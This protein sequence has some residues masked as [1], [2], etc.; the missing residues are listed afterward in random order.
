M[1][2][3][4]CSPLTRLPVC[5]YVQLQP[6]SDK[7]VL[8]VSDRSAAVWEY[9]GNQLLSHQSK[10]PYAVQPLNNQINTHVAQDEV[11]TPSPKD[12]ADPLWMGLGGQGEVKKVLSIKN[13]PVDNIMSASTI[14]LPEFEYRGAA[15]V[16]SL[17][18]NQEKG[19]AIPTKLQYVLYCVSGNKLHAAKLPS[20]DKN[21]REA[22]NVGNNAVNDVS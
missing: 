17:T 1:T 5:C 19:V 16:N 7:H 14:L 20:F 22:I 13:M 4:C 21:L 3:Q 10:I 15:T 9:N 6:L 18:L 11:P 2:M 12:R 8:S